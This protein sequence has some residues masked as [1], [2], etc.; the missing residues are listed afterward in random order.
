MKTYLSYSL[1]ILV[2][3]IVV[4]F[5]FSTL[6]A[7]PEN[8]AVHF[9]GAG[10]PSG[11]MSRRSYILLMLVFALAIPVF[12]VF[13]S[14]V[15][16]SLTSGNL[17][18]PNKA[19]WLSPKNKTRTVRYLQNHMAWFGSLNA[20]LIAYMHWLLLTANSLQP[21]HLP[22]NLFYTGMAAFLAGIL[23]WGILLMV[24]FMRMPKA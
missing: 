16:L 19:Y 11:F 22:N 5:I 14:I 12:I 4:A 8:I 23:F 9:N 3:I 17:N 6:N 24:K 20:S 1:F 21:P 13:F 15:A 18:I 10:T 2:E 7:L